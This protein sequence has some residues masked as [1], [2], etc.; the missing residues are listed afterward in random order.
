MWLFTTT[1]FF[2]IV[3][4][5]EDRAAGKLTV[6]ARV[7]SDLAALRS[8][9]LPELGP[10]NE[11]TGDYRFHAKAPRRAVARALA[12]AAEDIG[13]SNFKNE[14]ARTQGPVR[15]DLYARVWEAMWELQQPTHPSA[16]PPRRRSPSRR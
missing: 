2:S 14:V 13:Y 4:K 15:H 9:Y 7:K 16:R 11:R 1:G 10:I 3:E 5:P 12:L 8:R 6:R